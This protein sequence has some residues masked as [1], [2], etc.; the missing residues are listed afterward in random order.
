M[1][2]GAVYHQRSARYRRQTWYG[3]KRIVKCLLAVK[4]DVEGTEDV[5]LEHAQSFLASHQPDILC[6]ILLE[7]NSAAVQTALA[8]HGSG[9]TVWSV[10]R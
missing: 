7:S 3:T 9:S 1:G 6:E 10:A 5:V 2:D 4:I 8:P